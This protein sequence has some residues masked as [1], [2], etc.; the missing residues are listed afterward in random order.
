MRSFLILKSWIKSLYPEYT[1]FQST[2]FGFF[3]PFLT[4][5]LFWIN[6]D[7]K[8]HPK[9]FE[10]PESEFIEFEPRLKSAKKNSFHWVSA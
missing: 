7:V 3:P 5:Q 8:S 1:I 6:N 4:E 10:Q 2:Q 9:C